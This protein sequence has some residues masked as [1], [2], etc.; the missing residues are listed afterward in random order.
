MQLFPGMYCA[1]Y[2]PGNNRGE[3][4]KSLFTPP[5][6]KNK[7]GDFQGKKEVKGRIQNFR[8]GKQKNQYNGFLCKY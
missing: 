5:Q 6:K 3:G 2:M 4:V 1:H 8:H 7:G